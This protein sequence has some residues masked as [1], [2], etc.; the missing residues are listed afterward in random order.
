MFSHAELLKA[1]SSLSKF[2]MKLTRNRDNADDLLQSTILIALEKQD[3]FEQGTNLFSWTSKIMFNTFVSSYRHNSRFETLYDPQEYIDQVEVEST[4]EN[5]TDLSL[6]LDAMMLLSEDHQEILIKVCVEGRRYAEVAQQLGIPVGTVRSRLSRAREAL[7]D[8][9]NRERPRFP[10]HHGAAAHFAS[11]HSTS[12]V[13]AG[14]PEY[15]A[16][17]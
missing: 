4:Q 13:F 6:V 17:V 15:R 5:E 11:A 12:G 9:L 8:L 14:T 16:I 10:R 7:Q 3:H 1:T 2:A